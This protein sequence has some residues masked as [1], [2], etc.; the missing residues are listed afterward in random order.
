MRLPTP[1]TWPY[2]RLQVLFCIHFFIFSNIFSETVDKFDEK[3]S[4]IVFFFIN[5]LLSEREVLEK[6]V[7]QEV[8]EIY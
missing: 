6:T 8:L 1:P 4:F 7:I 2:G 3:C 5:F